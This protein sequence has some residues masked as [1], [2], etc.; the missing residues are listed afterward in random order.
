MCAALPGG[1]PNLVTD[2]F[3]AHLTL[4]HRNPRDLISFQTANDYY[5][6]QKSSHLVLSL[7]VFTMSHPVPGMLG[8]YHTQVG[9]WEQ[10]VPDE[11]TCTLVPRVG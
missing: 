7:T 9:E 3:A 4:E 11:L 8:G 10:R 1:D 6:C 5:Y 2:D